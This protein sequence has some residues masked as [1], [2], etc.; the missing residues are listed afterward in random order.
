VYENSNGD[1][2]TNTN[3]L[4]DVYNYYTAAN[5][6]P[7]GQDLIKAGYVKLREVSIGY[8]LPQQWFSK[9]FIGSGSLSIFGNNL[10]IWTNK[11]NDY[12]DPEV[13]SGGAS[14]EQ[15]FDFSARPS[16]RNYGFRLGL[17]F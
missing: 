9:T 16:V 4:T 6:K 8:K 2:V 7:A 1:Y 11:G 13:N 15:G 10:L 14:N 17:T 3:V 5:L 12:V